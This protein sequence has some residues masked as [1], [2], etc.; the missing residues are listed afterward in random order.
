MPVDKARM[1]SMHLSLSAR[2]LL[3]CYPFLMLCCCFNFQ[4]GHLAEQLQQ[5]IQSLPLFRRCWWIMM[6]GVYIMYIYDAQVSAC[7]C[8]GQP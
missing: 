8:V 5:R 6:P 2:C 4:G 3:S 7:A 1:P